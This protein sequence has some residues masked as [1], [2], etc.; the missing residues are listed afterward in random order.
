MPRRNISSGRPWE[1]VVGYSRAVR[2]GDY[3]HVSGTTATSDTG[4]VVGR[5][6]PYAQT[7]QTLRNIEW[8]LTQAGA[9]MAQ[10]VR[11]RMY[12][13]DISH[14]EAIGRAHGEVFRDIRPAATMVQ[15]AKLIDPDMLVEIEADAYVGH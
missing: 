14:W 1:P 8:A 6:D 11:T 5:G 9:S 12:V 4:S 13:T 15:V 10:V 3:V 7:V 2:V